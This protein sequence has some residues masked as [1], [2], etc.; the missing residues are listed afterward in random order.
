METVFE[1]M[2]RLGQKENQKRF[3]ELQKI[4]YKYKVDYAKG[5]EWK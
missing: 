5:V 3:M 2:D 4:P 1:R